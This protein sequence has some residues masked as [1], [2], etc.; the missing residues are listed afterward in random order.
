MVN[1]QVYS[2][3]KYNMLIYICLFYLFLVKQKILS[4]VSPISLNF[5]L[6]ILILWDFFFIQ[7]YRKEKY[8]ILD[9]ILTIPAIIGLINTYIRFYFVFILVIL[10]ILGKEW[11]LYIRFLII[12]F[13]FL[14]LSYYMFLV[15]TLLIIILIEKLKFNVIFNKYKNGEKN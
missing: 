8:Y 3:I 4:F 1:K 10:N 13:I 2:M 7:E 5:L 11:K 9:G 6:F 15:F 12:F 14:G